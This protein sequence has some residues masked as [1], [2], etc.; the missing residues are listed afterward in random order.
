[1]EKLTDTEAH[2][3]SG[4]LTTNFELVFSSELFKG[5]KRHTTR[6]LSSLGFSWTPPGPVPDSPGA[7]GSA[8]F[9]IWLS[10]LFKFTNSSKFWGFF[11]LQ[12]WVTLAWFL[13]S[14]FFQ[15]KT[16]FYSSPP[17]A[18]EVRTGLFQ[19][20]NPNRVI[21]QFVNLMEPIKFQKTPKRNLNSDI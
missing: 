20:T 1:M 9:R 19:V 12:K 6:I 13:S 18:L 8:M 5:R 3:S 2:W 21:G 17:F 7:A 16:V 14:S 11:F 15:W 4:N 10:K